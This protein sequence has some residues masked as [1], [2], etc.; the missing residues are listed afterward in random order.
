MI[1]RDYIKPEIC[2][3][4]DKKSN[5]GGWG[6]LRT[7]KVCDCIHYVRDL[8]LEGCYQLVKEPSD[9]DLI[10]STIRGMYWKQVTNTYADSLNIVAKY[11]SMPLL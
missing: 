6:S 8:N 7:C 4:G 5:H 2:I 9:A 10:E 11:E 3:C 1:V